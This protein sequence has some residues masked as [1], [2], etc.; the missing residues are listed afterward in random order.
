MRPLE[1]KGG[2]MK[3]EMTIDKAIEA[4]AKLVNDLERL[5]DDFE[6]QTGMRVNTI[7]RHLTRALD[8]NGHE[9]ARIGTVDVEV[10]L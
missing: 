9:K 1:R 7:C 4:R 6:K 8:E 2:E 10:I 3:P 5:V